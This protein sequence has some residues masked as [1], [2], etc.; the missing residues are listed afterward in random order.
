MTTI[1]GHLEVWRKE[2][3]RA[4]LGQV[5][6]E[7]AKV[8]MQNLA[9]LIEE[10][11]AKLLPSFAEAVM[12]PQQVQISDLGQRLEQAQQEQ[13]ETAATVDHFEQKLDEANQQVAAAEHQLGLERLK[14]TSVENRCA[15]L[16]LTVDRMKEE[17]SQLGQR[18]EVTAGELAAAKILITALERSV[19]DLRA[20]VTAGV[21]RIASLV[22]QLATND[23]EMKA[24]KDQ[25]EAKDA[26]VKA[27]HEDLAARRVN[28]A[29]LEQEI[30]LAKIR[31]KEQAAM[32]DAVV[33]ER[34]VERA[35]AA[36]EATELRAS[37]ADLSRALS[38]TKPQL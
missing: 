27:V 8:L 20:A 34:E 4:A 29:R 38:N 31:G 14:T 36:R 9:K 35:S 17:S 33:R 10:G 23:T 28:V 24:M 1:Q 5:A 15:A 3:G 30:E 13:A 25:L 18:M 16:S 21:T 22:D 7:E 11:T 12:R 37:I 2:V 32:M 26:E 19:E 6:P